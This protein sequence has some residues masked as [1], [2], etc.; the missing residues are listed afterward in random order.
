MS[1]VQRVARKKSSLTRDGEIKTSLVTG[2]WDILAMLLSLRLTVSNS[3][4][5]GCFSVG[6]AN[7]KHAE[8]TKKAK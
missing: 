5:V 6:N 2:R 7:D 8:R 1:V 4:V 3:W